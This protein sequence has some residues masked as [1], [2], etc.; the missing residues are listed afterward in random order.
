VIR[1]RLADAVRTA[2]QAVAAD[3]IALGL[4]AEPFDA[5]AVAVEL[6]RP[7]RKEHGDW[8][9]NVALQ[10][11]KPAGAKP[12]DLAAALVTALGTPPGVE[13]IEIAGAGFINF[14][15]SLASL[16]ETIREVEH[17]GEGWGRVIPAKPE[18]I[19][20]EFVSANPTGPLHVGHGRWAAIGD[21]LASVLEAAG[22]QVKRE[23]Y[24]NDFGRQM[25]LFGESVRA[26]YL[27]EL[28]R[29]ASFPEDGYHGTYVVDLAKEIVAEVGDKYADADADAFRKIGEERM[30]AHQRD[31]LERFGVRFDVW[32]S[33]TSLHASGAVAAGI[34][35]LKARGHTYEQ[36]GALWLRS[37]DFGD[38]KDRVIVRA[39]G[40]PT[41]LAPDVAYY[42]DKRSRGF[43]RLIY[44]VGA[45]HHGYTARVHAM[46][47]ALGD[48]PAETEFIVGQFVNLHRGGEPVRM[49][50]R[51][52]E[53]ITFEEL[54]DEVGVDAARYTFLRHSSDT[55]IEF[56]MELVVRQSQDNPVFYVQYAHA[57]ISSILRYAQ[58]Q[59]IAV[60][61]VGEVQLDLLAHPSELDLIR[62]ISELPEIVEA[63]TRLRSPHPLARYAEDL[64]G[65]FHAFYRDCRVVTED[66]ALTQARLH[67]A[68]AARV[69]LA[70]VL[71][72]LGVSA[73]E[74]MERTPDD[75]E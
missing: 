10:L 59:G 68:T 51:T 23:F 20:V 25:N 35:R 14:K 54:I 30:L 67:L 22:H 47:R 57:R 36:A 15:L 39:D 17:A 13:A 53:L 73:P 48:E 4:Q 50:K 70:N 27:A 69:A 60:E 18:R 71:R 16:T 5:S 19:Q 40:T 8:S 45:D 24:V 28:G 66:A 49:S 43:D 11:A 7:A 31:V 61:P 38:D 1:G 42:L 6:E 64:A 37:T 29:E 44:L 58:E 12:R 3:P 41:Y 46:I 72:L 56:D 63:A 21:A 26:R 75:Q 65:L 62:K 9:T 74:K 34:E 33:E 52:G 2:V 32:F 55:P